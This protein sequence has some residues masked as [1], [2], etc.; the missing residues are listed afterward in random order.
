M[1]ES[2]RKKSEFTPN[3]TD[4]GAIG[5]VLPSDDELAAAVASSDEH[6]AR[7]EEL[8]P[9][10][11]IGIDA[12]SYVCAVLDLKI[13]MLRQEYFRTRYRQKGYVRVQGQPT[14]VG[15]ERAEV[16]IK[17]RED[18]EHDLRRRRAQIE[19]HVVEG[20]MHRSALGGRAY[21]QKELPT[22]THEII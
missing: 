8:A 7:S 9:G 15:Y 14:V 12:G 11:V 2:K 13:P 18:A 19:N 6:R 22:R 16:W 10:T 5:F 21:V 17:R 4:E 1:R 3:A 20:R